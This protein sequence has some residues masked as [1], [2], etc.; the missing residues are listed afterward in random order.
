MKEKMRPRSPTQR[1]HFEI[2]SILLNLFLDL[3]LIAVVVMMVLLR[4][5]EKPK[6]FSTI[7]PVACV[8]IFIWLF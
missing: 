1:E 3:H 8:C 4:G 7:A 5:E 2:L 6:Q